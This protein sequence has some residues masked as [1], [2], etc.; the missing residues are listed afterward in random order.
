M[1]PGI[2]L[3]LL[4]F[5]MVFN[6]YTFQLS[7]ISLNIECTFP[8]NNLDQYRDIPLTGLYCRVLPYNDFSNDKIIGWVCETHKKSRNLITDKDIKEEINDVRDANIIIDP[9]T[10]ALVDLKCINISTTLATS[11]FSLS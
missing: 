10:K 3:T 4:Q 1:K 8:S 11:N 7:N 5:L 2:K 6:V 9:E